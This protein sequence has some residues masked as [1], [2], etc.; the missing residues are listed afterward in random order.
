MW[1]SKI[2][3]QLKIG[4]CGLPG[5][6]WRGAVVFNDSRINYECYANHLL[7]PKDVSRECVKG[8]WTGEVP[9]CG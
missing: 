1:K 6:P 2:I 5:E 7:V 8:H 4:E 9:K 3:F